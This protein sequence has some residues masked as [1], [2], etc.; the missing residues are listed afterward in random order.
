[1]TF[2]I[3]LL[4]A[5]QGVAEFLPI[6]SSGHLAIAEKLLGVDS[7]GS[8]ME[9][10]LHFGTLL[11]V[12]AFY[13]RRVALLLLGLALGVREAWR[14]TGLLLLGCIPAVA[15]YAM[16]KGFF[17]RCEG[18]GV[19]FIGAML[20][21][22]GA[23][24]VSTRWARKGSKGEVGV[25]EALLVG[26]AQA[27]ALLPG[28][29]RS[30]STIAT[31]RHLGVEGRA[32]ADYSFLMSAVLLTGASLQA[33]VKGGGAADLGGICAGTAILAVA[34]SAVV[35]YYSL[36]MLIGVLAGRRFWMFGLYCLVAGAVAWAA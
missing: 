9:L 6:S 21:A 14:Q 27:A 3:L 32:A 4:A 24:L 11:A 34:V 18:R 25:L 35:G 16:F 22:T 2:K 1:M 20:V 31:A 29:S 23:L 12:L 10:L 17:E 26:L 28:I 33:A 5:F 36:R 13:R 8:G 15:A 30:G 7:P 19:P